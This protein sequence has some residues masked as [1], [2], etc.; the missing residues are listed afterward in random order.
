MVVEVVIEVVLVVIVLE[1]VMIIVIVVV[2]IL[3]CWPL[4]RVISD[5]GCPPC[6][7]RTCRVVDYDR[8]REG[9]GGSG[10]GPKRKC[11]FLFVGSNRKVFIGC[12]VMMM[13]R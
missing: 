9:V 11:V 10:E 3:S 6:F 12:S 7:A 4:I 8:E 13:T 5:A 1:V 2:V